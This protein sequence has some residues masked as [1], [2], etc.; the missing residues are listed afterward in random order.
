MFLVVIDNVLRLSALTLCVDETATLGFRNWVTEL[1]CRFYPK[2][3]SLIQAIKSNEQK[4]KLTVK[5]RI[6]SQK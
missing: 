5:V 1:F 2:L 6:F 4:S 3:N